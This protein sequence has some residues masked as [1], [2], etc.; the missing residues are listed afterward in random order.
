MTYEELREIYED[1]NN[2]LEHNTQFID[3]TNW[4]KHCYECATYCKIYRPRKIDEN[5]RLIPIYDDKGQIIPDK[6]EYVSP[7]EFR[8][9]LRL[10]NSIFGFKLPVEEGWYKY[11]K[12][13]K[14]WEAIV[15]LS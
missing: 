2:F 14:K 15:F 13:T 4:N 8:R 7:Y 6:Y 10:I 5:G 12:Q 11:N 9:Y 1:W 3:A